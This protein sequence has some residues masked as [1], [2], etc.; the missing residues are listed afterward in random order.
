MRKDDNMIDEQPNASMEI[1][2]TSVDGFENP[3]MEENKQ[4]QG[5]RTVEFAMPEPPMPESVILYRSKE[6]IQRWLD[7]EKVGQ[8]LARTKNLDYN[9]DFKVKF[10]DEIKEYFERQPEGKEVRS[11]FEIL[12]PGDSINH[13]TVI[14]S[15]DDRGL[16]LDYF[17]RKTTI[18]NEMEI[19]SVLIKEEIEEWKRLIKEIDIEN[20]F[21][22]DDDD[23][24]SL[25]RVL[26]LACM[27]ID[28][29]SCDGLYI[30][31]DNKLSA[32]IAAVMAMSLKKPIYRDG[33]GKKVIAVNVDYKDSKEPLGN[34]CL[35]SVSL[36]NKDNVDV[37]E[38]DKVVLC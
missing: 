16:E 27:A 36:T 19:F 4:S 24:V 12:E 5:P 7:E 37:A 21:A 31:D 11:V 35:Y 32:M 15:S 28:M 3:Y 30:G 2:Q 17:G 13:Q 1:K 23:L 25:Y 29:E 38:K 14:S 22:K 34:E 33:A 9:E 26:E 20:I 8:L 18:V 6:G 10:A